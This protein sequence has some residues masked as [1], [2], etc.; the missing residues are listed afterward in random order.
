MPLPPKNGGL[1][2]Q[3]IS[4]I[5]FITMKVRRIYRDQPE[6]LNNQIITSADA[7]TN[8]DPNALTYNFVVALPGRAASPHTERAYIRWIDEYLVALAGMKPTTGD[9]R[10]QRMM[11]LPI[12]VLKQVLMPAQLRTWLGML[13][14]AG[15]GK[16]GI[17]QARAA[18]VTLAHLLSE[19]GWIDDYTSAAITNVRAPSAAD[20]Q[21]PGRWLSLDQIH[22]LIDGAERIATTE[23][24]AKRNRLALTM[25]CTMA[26]RREE[27]AAVRWGDLSVQNERVVLSVRGKGRKTATI[28][29]PRSVMNAI[30]AWRPMVEPDSLRPAPTSPLLRR[31]WKGGRVS[32]YGLTADGIWLVVSQAALAAGIDHVAPHDLRR[33]VAGALQQSGV[34]IDKISKLLRHSNVAITERYLNKLPQKNEGAILMSDVLGWEDADPADFDFMT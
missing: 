8:V 24:Q 22:Q 11:T 18:V 15:H 6:Q 17:N 23:A 33:S 10:L 14:R 7:L 19:A 28:D 20:G 5:Q 2:E 29:V 1:S 16:Q 34:S 25:L 27:L 13:S 30:H 12:P 9:A 3:S 32:R 21:R 31:V 26:L 4:H